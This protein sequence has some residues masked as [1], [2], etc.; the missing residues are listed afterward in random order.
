MYYGFALEKN[1]YD[2]IKFRI[3]MD[4]NDK[5]DFLE[6]LEKFVKFNYVP[7]KSFI[8]LEVKGISLN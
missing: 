8:S 7:Y 3:F 5:L 4:C 6:N 1:K 2:R